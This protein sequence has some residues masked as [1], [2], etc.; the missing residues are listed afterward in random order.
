LF[1]GAEPRA[2]ALVL[3]APRDLLANER[4]AIRHARHATVPRRCAT[5]LP[6]AQF[7]RVNEGDEMGAPSFFA[8]CSGLV[9]V[10]VP[11]GAFAQTMPGPV[12]P[13]V[14]LAFLPPPAVAQPVPEHLEVGNQVFDGSVSGFRSYL[15]T[16]QTTDPQ[17]FAQLDPRVRSLE[18][19]VA[20]AREVL[21]AG[22]IVGLVSTVYAFTGRKTCNEPALG[23]PSFAADSQA[24][25][26][27][28][29][30][31]IE[32]LAAFTGL[33]IGAIALGGI[34]AYAVSPHRSDM[35]DLVNEHNRISHEP[36]RLQLG[37]D[38]TNRLALGGVSTAF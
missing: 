9:A 38:S 37:Y 21:V 23:D 33:G 11:G 26:D 8:V 24:W 15:D 2:A 20:N 32:H 6:G 17:L 13:P 10:A 1:A 14:T 4:I 25:G 5:V 3:D 29:S 36:I 22:V 12:S 34:I 16:K 30:D 31:N 28:N 27:C 19:Q 18:S 7:L 35:L